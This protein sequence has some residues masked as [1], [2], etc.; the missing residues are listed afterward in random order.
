MTTL[1]GSSLHRQPRNA[2]FHDGI[3]RCLTQ[4]LLKRDFGLELHLPPNRLCPPVPNRCS[5]LAHI[6]VPLHTGVRLNYVLWIQDIAFE[7]WDAFLA[8]AAEREGKVR[9]QGLDMYALFFLIPEHAAEN[10]FN[11]VE[12]AHPPYTLSLLVHLT[13]NGHSLLPVRILSFHLFVLDGR[14]TRA[15]QYLV[16][17]RPNQHRQ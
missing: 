5:P 15:R 17:P 3:S 8:I 13:Q 12:R 7:H 10:I 11:P 14:V 9:V 4:A 6:H 16:S 1:S 2:R